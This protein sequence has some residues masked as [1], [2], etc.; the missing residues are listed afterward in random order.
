M[1]KIALDLA[2]S[3]AIAAPYIIS[4]MLRHKCEDVFS[5]RIGG[6]MS[7]QHQHERNG[8]ENWK[9]CNKRGLIK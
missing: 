6:T 9:R 7:A 4:S 8:G 5:T 2:I 1:K 3:S